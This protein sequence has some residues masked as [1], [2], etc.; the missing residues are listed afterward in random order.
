MASDIKYDIM[1]VGS[2]PA[3]SVAAFHASEGGRRVCLVDR[4]E[5]VGTPVRCGEGV[6]VNGISRSVQL[7][8]AWVK[9]RIS[10]IKMV[11]PSGIEVNLT[12]K[13]EGLI[14]DRQRMEQDLVDRAVRAGV[15]FVKNTTIVSV[16]QTGGGY[17]CTGADGR[18]YE[19]PCVIL[20]DGVESRLARCMGWKTA[21]P[22]GDLDTCAFAH[23]RSA[24]IEQD[25]CVFHF[26]KKYAP[27]GYLWVFPRGDGWANVGL[28]VIGS[29]SRPGRARELLEQ[30]INERF[31]G[32][33]VADMHCGGVPLT[34]WLKPLVK[35]GVMVVGDAARQVNAISGAG[36]SFG[37]LAGKMAGSVAAEAF[38]GGTLN[39]SHLHVY[40][41]RWAVDCGKQQLRSCALKDVIIGFDDAFLDVIARHFERR[42]SGRITH[43]NILMRALSRYPLLM[44]KAFLLFR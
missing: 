2:G 44:L 41:K 26:G 3:G 8:P 18:T 43:V 17:R 13:D 10:K 11:S 40:E 38:A 24:S 31:P 42:N 14:L 19:S 1:V 32:A 39:Q 28:G 34:K 36:I 12:S 7:N 16:D 30:F 15:T 5:Q 23:V 22:L 29:E 35:G 9:C 20:A 27:G 21:L 33:P 25:K 6:G 37:M 4:R